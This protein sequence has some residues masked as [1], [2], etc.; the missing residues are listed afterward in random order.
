MDKDASKI[1]EIDSFF[2]WVIFR[3]KG[4]STLSV[5]IKKKRKTKAR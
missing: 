3:V 2:M 4:C 5:A 1:L